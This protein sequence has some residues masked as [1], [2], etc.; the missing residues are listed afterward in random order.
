[1]TRKDYEAFAEAV[2]VEQWNAEHDTWTVGQ[3][4]NMMADVFR[5][6]NPRFDRDRF[7]AACV[8]PKIAGKV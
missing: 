2:R 8:N 3:V 6:D 7:V 4:I 1:M 5:A